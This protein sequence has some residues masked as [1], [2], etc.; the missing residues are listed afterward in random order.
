MIPQEP[1]GKGK[2]ESVAEVLRFALTHPPIGGKVVDT[3]LTPNLKRILQQSA[4][5]TISEGRNEDTRDALARAFRFIQYNNR[6]G[7]KI[8]DSWQAAYL[9]FK[10]KADNGMG[11]A[12]VPVDW[13]PRIA[14]VDGSP[15]V[16]AQAICTACRPESDPAQAVK[17]P[18][19]G[20][21][22]ADK[23]TP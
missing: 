12:E 13:V 6:A 1:K 22:T 7:W 3:W 18:G 20:P 5:T 8:R 17:P 4:R 19:G 10:E 2:P 14:G 9:G 23:L 21:P 11:P 16:E 15:E